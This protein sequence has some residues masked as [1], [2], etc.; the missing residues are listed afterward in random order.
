MQE[1]IRTNSIFS[2]SEFRGALTRL[3]QPHQIRSSI[4]AGERRREGGKTDKQELELEIKC[5]QQNS[6]IQP[7]QKDVENH[8]WQGS[9]DC[10]ILE[11]FLFYCYTTSWT[12]NTNC[13]KLICRNKTNQWAGENKHELHVQ[14]RGETKDFGDIQF[15]LCSI[16]S[17]NPFSCQHFYHSFSYTLSVHWL[18]LLTVISHIWSPATVSPL[19]F[20]V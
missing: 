8:V 9:T 5:C 1:D 19:W 17:S 16:F 6:R 11:V 15:I 3:G 20:T 4:P 14:R 18:T 10:A 13:Y 12:T 7:S 2:F